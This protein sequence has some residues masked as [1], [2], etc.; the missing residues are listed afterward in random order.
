MRSWSARSGHYLVLLVVGAACVT[1]PNRSHV[2]DVE[3]ELDPSFQVAWEFRLFPELGPIDTSY[4]W[5]GASVPADPRAP[6]C[7]AAAS[8]PTSWHVE[9]VETHSQFVAALEVA[10]PRALVGTARTHFGVSPDAETLGGVLVAS[11]GDWA[12]RELGDQQALMQVSVWIGPEDGYPTIGRDTASRQFHARQCRLAA[13]DGER[14]LVEFA[15]RGPHATEE[16]LAAVWPVAR[17]RYLRVLISGL[18]AA[19]LP[20]ARAIISNM[21]A[22]PRS[23]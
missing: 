13:D 6:P 16:Y 4:R 1:S 23:R 14:R 9:H 18:D 11:W 10:L 22:F 3:H 12:E 7:T 8:R 17:E 21:Y 15:I 5:M 2:R 20:A 19:S